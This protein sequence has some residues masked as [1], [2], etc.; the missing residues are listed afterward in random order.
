MPRPMPPLADEV[1]KRVGESL[2]LAAAADL[3]L[4]ESR[5][6]AA[7]RARWTVN[8]VETLY[9]IAYLR[10]F[11]QWEL[12]L[13]AALLRYLC[14]YITK[15]GVPVPVPGKSVFPTLSAAQ[16]AMYG[17]NDYLLWHNP[18]NVIARAQKFVAKSHFENVV[19]SSKPRIEHFANVRHR[20]TH[21]QAD[22]RKKFDLA[23]MV[24][25]G[26][27]YRGARPGRFLRDW[28]TSVTPNRRWLDVV[29]SEIASLA[30]QIA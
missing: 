29:C 18:D 11:I 12:F 28:D 15:A 24:L 14:G 1:S 8:R 4:A 10:V 25:A 30:V 26:R 17:S 21:G 13:E 3:T 2:A 6:H 23:T 20:I 5:R 19:L 7:L 27:R 9:E 22:A 16:T